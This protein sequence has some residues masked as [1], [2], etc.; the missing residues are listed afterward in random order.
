M[1]RLAAAFASIAG[2][3]RGRLATSGKTVIR[4]VRIAIAVSNVQVSKNRR[5]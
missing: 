4:S 2:G 3:R 5:W 1:S